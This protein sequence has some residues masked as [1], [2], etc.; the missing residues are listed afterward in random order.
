ML[1]SLIR[2]ITYGSAHASYLG[3]MNPVRGQKTSVPHA[4]FVTL[5]RSVDI[6]GKLAYGSAHASYL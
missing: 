2:T 5:T 6:T 3:G 4:V 1:L